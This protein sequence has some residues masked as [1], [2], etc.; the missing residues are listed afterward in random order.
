MAAQPP[1]TDGAFLALIERQ[2]HCAEVQHHQS[3]TAQDA[4][5]KFS[6]EELRLIDTQQGTRHAGH[7]AVAQLNGI[8]LPRPAASEDQG[9]A[10]RER[11]A[12]GSSIVLFKVGADAPRDFAIHESLVAENSTFVRTAWSKD[13][14]EAKDRIIALPNDEPAVFQ[15]YQDWLYDRKV[16]TQAGSTDYKLLINAYIFGERMLDVRFKNAVIRDITRVLRTTSLFD[17]TL[18][19]LIYDNTPTDSKLRKLLRDIYA[20]LGSET[21]FDEDKLPHA[22]NSEFLRDVNREHMRLRRQISLSP[23]FANHLAVSANYIQPETADEAATETKD[24]PDLKRKRE[25]DDEAGNTSKR[26]AKSDGPFSIASGK[27]LER[28]NSA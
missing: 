15:L 4:Y 28:R 24:S 19:N 3:I 22:I 17:L 1:P 18:T 25:S 7:L 27:E 13:F 6:F 16:Y 12:L 5:S 8:P 9:D 23:P 26:P 2:S 20:W 11:S 14:K 21:W 10:A